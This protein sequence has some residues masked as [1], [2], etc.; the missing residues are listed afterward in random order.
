MSKI[1][2]I[3]LILLNSLI[4]I[5]T[6][7][8]TF[9]LSSR[10]EKGVAIT[11][12]TKNLYIVSSSKSNNIINQYYQIIQNN[13]NIQTQ[14]PFG[15]NFEMVESSINRKTN[16]SMLL[17]ADSTTNKINLYSYNITGPIIENK[18]PKLLDSISTEVSNKKISLLSMG[19]DKYLLSYCMSDN[20]IAFK[21]FKYTSY[22]GY[23]SKGNSAYDLNNRL[24]N[25]LVS[26][27]LLYE[28]FPVCLY[29]EK[30]IVAGGNKYSLNLIGLNLV[31]NF[32][33][34]I[35]NPNKIDLDADE[36]NDFLFFKAIYFSDDY[37]AFCY[38]YEGND[39][40]FCDLRKIKI[41]FL[42]SQFRISILPPSSP[43]QQVIQ[44]CSND[45]YKFDLIKVDNDKILVCCEN[46][47][48]Q[49]I[50]LALININNDFT[51]SS[52]NI[53]T[54]EKDVKTT[55]TLFS[56]ELYNNNYGII[57][58]D[59]NN[60]VNYEFIDLPTCS[61]N[62][63]N[64]KELP[65]D[66]SEE[67]TL[68]LSDDELIFSVENQIFV[69]STIEKK[70][71]I[72]SLISKDED[73]NIFNYKLFN[74][75]NEIKIG[76]IID[77]GDSLRIG[78]TDKVL[79]SGK[80]FIEVI[81]LILENG[82]ISKQ[83]RTCQIEFDA[84]CYKG[85]RSCK[86]Y[87]TA[88]NEVSN[89][90]C[91][92]CKSNY[93]SLNDLCLTECSLIPGFHDVYQTKTCTF[94]ELEF[95]NDCQYKI[96]YIGEIG[97][98]EY[99]NICLDSSFCPEEYPYVY[100]D[101]GECIEKCRYSEL[102]SGECYISNIIGAQED[103]INE[104]SKNIETSADDI[105]E[106][107]D[108]ERVNKSIVIYGT[109]VTI[110]ITDTIRMY[111]EK[112]KNSFVSNT[113][114]DQCLDELNPSE[115]YDKELI[116]LKIDLRRN[117]TIA[118][119]VEY[120]IFK[121]I[122]PPS[123]SAEEISEL[124]CTKN[125]IVQSPIFVSQSYLEKI[126]E[127]YDEG[128][129][130]FNITEKFY[131]DLCIPYYDK[132]FDAD[133]TLGKRQ[134]IY[135]E[136]NGNLCE[137][138]CKYIRFDISLNKA[139]CE[140]PFKKEF[141]IDITKEKVFDYIEEKDQKVFYKHV[142]SNLETIKCVKYLFSKDGF[143]YNFGSY[144]MMIMI[145]GFVSVSVIWFIIG[146]D[147]ILSSIREILDKILIKN[148]LAFQ[149]KVK[150]KFEEMRGK[151]GN[152]K[153]TNLNK[154]NPPKKNGN[155][156]GEE[157]GNKS[158][159][160]INIDNNNVN[161]IDRN[162]G[163]NEK[164]DIISSSN[165]MIEKEEEEKYI[166]KKGPKK[167]LHL[168]R[169][170]ALDKENEVPEDIIPIKRNY[171]EKLTDIEIDLLPYEVAK[172]LDKRKF[173]GYYWSLLK[174]RQLIIFTFLVFDDFN[175]FLIKLI[176]FF[177]LLSINFVYNSI[178]FY[179]K[180]IDKIYDNEGKYSLK[181][182]I[183]NIFICSV[184][185]SLTIVLIRFIITCH[186]RFIKLKEIEIY[187]K[188]QKESFSMHRSLLTRYIVFIIIG[189]ILLLFFWYYITC[190]C[191]IFHFTQNHLFLNAF[192]SFLLSMIYPFIYCLLPAMFRYLAFKKN[193]KCYYNFSQYI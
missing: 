18:N 135:Y 50:N 62:Q 116:I 44:P 77:P 70:Y 159:E 16:E 147:I 117:D 99:A 13:N 162:G 136:I 67:A 152:K 11:S 154:N 35:I 15:K 53:K 133:L 129:D 31:F 97:N 24:N 158:I 161:I 174:L 191:G 60:K 160:T 21:L 12:F 187:E 74:G 189:I 56:Y 163:E 61:G 171:N 7:D 167:N 185:F 114:F 120:K 192:L 132:K 20:K 9:K 143:K 173:K 94:E 23:Q 164:E 32:Y 29:S 142:L 98:D 183:L 181:I 137:A 39:Q 52:P 34:G 131:S 79:F 43:S 30:S 90:N 96:W 95:V 64:I 141:D 25:Y 58:D 59:S 48:L 45:L 6:D 140:C 41:D 19:N 126:K 33:D 179:D 109:N 165:K 180:I 128:Y 86:E 5:F 151:N 105:F 134:E 51:L 73:Q 103:A 54:K 101:T 190:F 68:S 102:V 84:I 76:D 104:I 115:D 17:I 106:K 127:V 113:F 119:Q 107:N 71:K 168:I 108:L 188:A 170:L 81:P 89:H 40:V 26:C 75:V 78:D 27:F 110:E 57:F 118:A 111:D 125:I 193:Q 172:T 146:E 83:G 63:D 38:Y 122:G 22:E 80:F 157:N 72:N 8:K 3:V 184:A 4:R 14:T 145:I 112:N 28:Q 169:S 65:N 156:G 144:F 178:L 130:I 85:C 88:S 150:K 2:F 148:D 36:S 87:S 121:I 46:S 182:Q 69:G 123:P 49:K 1:L 149:E 186:K 138:N 92:S 82:A 42:S 177:L 100:K 153:I 93:Y 175:I 55:L 66:G 37:F 91:L 176:A 47:D 166:K 124:S 10:G 139:I 155:N